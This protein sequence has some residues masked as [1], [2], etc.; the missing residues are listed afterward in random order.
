MT[1]AER[2]RRIVAE[3]ADVPEDE[4]TALEIDSLTTVTLVESLEDGF[5]VRFSPREVTKEAF[6][7]LATITALVASK[8]GGAP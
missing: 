7:T 5:D 4:T 3:H 1:I 2:V 6:R 8:T